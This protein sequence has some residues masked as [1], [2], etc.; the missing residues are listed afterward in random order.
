MWSAMLEELLAEYF[1]AIMRWQSVLFRGV[2]N[3][4]QTL[5]RFD[6]YRLHTV[7]SVHLLL[8]KPADGHKTAH[9]T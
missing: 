2:A 6:I 9:S 4:D 8:R 7:R 1:W 3:W 5:P